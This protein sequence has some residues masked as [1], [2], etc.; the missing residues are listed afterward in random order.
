MVTRTVS[1]L[2]A[3]GWQAPVEGQPPVQ[4]VFGL[5]LVCAS[6]INNHIGQMAYLVRQLG[7]DTNEPP[8][9]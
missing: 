3:A 8:V 9:W 2:D 1:S 6:H 5:V 7:H 4:T